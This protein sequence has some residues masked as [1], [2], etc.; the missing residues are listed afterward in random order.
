LAIRKPIL[1]PQSND[2]PL[3]FTPVNG[4]DRISVCIASVIWISPPA[5]LG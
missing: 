1:L 4:C 5:P 2:L 3:Y